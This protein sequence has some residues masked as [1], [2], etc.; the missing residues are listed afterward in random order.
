MAAGN[1]QADYQAAGFSSGGTGA[2]LAR[3]IIVVAGA[4]ALVA[5]L[6]TFV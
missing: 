2:R 3:A 1:P 5:S 4:S 6:T